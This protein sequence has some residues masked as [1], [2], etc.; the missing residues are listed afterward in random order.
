MKKIANLLVKILMKSYQLKNNASKK[1]VYK[2]LEAHLQNKL[3]GVK[4][5]AIYA[6]IKR[7]IW[8]ACDQVIM[9]E[10]KKKEIKIKNISFSAGEFCARRK[11]ENLEKTMHNAM[12]IIT[13]QIL[14]LHV[15]KLAMQL[16]NAR[17]SREKKAG[18]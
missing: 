7:I 14:K 16:I 5:C 11:V 2:E 10:E 1:M 8:R 6:L 17:R 12:V 9:G 4:A 18:N 13:C 15:A 3:T